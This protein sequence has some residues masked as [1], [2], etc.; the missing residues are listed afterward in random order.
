MPVVQVHIRA[1]FG[2]TDLNHIIVI[3]YREGCHCTACEL[4]GLW[5]MGIVGNN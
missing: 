5:T 2:G 3:K 1:E 4:F